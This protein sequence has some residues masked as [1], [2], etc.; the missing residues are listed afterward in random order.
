MIYQQTFTFKNAELIADSNWQVHPCRISS[1]ADRNNYQP[2]PST[3][4]EAERIR[5]KIQKMTEE[6]GGQT[7]KFA[8][9][10]NKTPQQSK[11][12]QL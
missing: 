11:Y 4:D 12:E 3:G 2:T 7:V 8:G 1:V 9:I 6:I 5:E 10:S